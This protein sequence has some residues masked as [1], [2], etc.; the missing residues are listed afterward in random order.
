M[1]TGLS[2]AKGF[3]SII[4]FVASLDRAEGVNV[5]VVMAVPSLAYLDVQM[6][7]SEDARLV[8]AYQGLKARIL[9]ENWESPE[10]LIH[11]ANCE[12][13][14]LQLISPRTILTKDP[15]ADLNALFRRLVKVRD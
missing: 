7:D 12:G 6:E 9:R 11:F 5:G 15:P 4:Q 13:N 2:A 10:D 1:P 3:Y 8:V 14:H